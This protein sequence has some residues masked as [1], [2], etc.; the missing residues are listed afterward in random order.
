V[1]P[2]ALLERCVEQ[3]ERM[4]RQGDLLTECALAELIEDGELQRH[5]RRMRRI[6]QSRRDAL[7]AALERYLPGVLV[8][9]APPGGMALWAR[10]HGVDVERWAARASEQGQVIWT[11]RDFSFA[12]RPEPFLRLGFALRTAE[13]SAR[14]IERLARCVPRAVSPARGGRRRA[15]GG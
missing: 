8:A 5:V 15:V 6:Y 1:A 13:E 2:A 12:R 10:A 9:S 3:R 14:E 7:V 11:A 4:D